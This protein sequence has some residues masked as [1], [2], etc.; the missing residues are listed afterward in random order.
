[1][2]RRVVI[3]GGTS[4]IGKET[5]KAFLAEGDKVVFTGRNEKA[6][7]EIMKEYKTEANAG[8]LWFI[9]GD[10]QD[11]GFLDSFYDFVQDKIGGCDVL[12]P[13]AAIALG[14]MVHETEMEMFDRQFGINFRSVFYLC[15]KILPDMMDQKSGRI[16]LVASDAGR[17]GAYNMSVYASTKAAIINLAQSIGIDYARYGITANVVCPSATLTPM[18]LTDQE[19]WIIKLFEKNNPSGRLGNPDD[20]ANTIVFLAS[21]K[22]A[23]IVGQ[24]IS[25]DGGLQAWG[26]E[27]RQERSTD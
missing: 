25:V 5:V 19:D 22:A 27:A 13:C 9:A 16:V 14:G 12:V 3:T 26:G 11:P 15:K 1:M 17:A 8:K 21:E 18:F 4:G 6:A 24:V 2:N 20:I 10:V 23:Y 7:S